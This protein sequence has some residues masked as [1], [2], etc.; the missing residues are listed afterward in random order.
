MMGFNCTT[1]G[2]YHDQLPMC[3]GQSPLHGEGSRDCRGG[4]AWLAGARCYMARPI[5]KEQDAEVLAKLPL[6]GSA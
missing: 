6:A 5:I 1:C 2:E 3:F 4:I